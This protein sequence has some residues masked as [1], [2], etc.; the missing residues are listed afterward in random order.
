MCKNDK[1]LI[2]KK[3]NEINGPD[4]IKASYDLQKLKRY[5]DFKKS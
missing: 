1:M 2:D 4:H 5:N 3:D